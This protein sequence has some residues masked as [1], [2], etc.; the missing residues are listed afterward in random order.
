MLG[1]VWIDTNF[2]ELQKNK[3][4]YRDLQERKWKTRKLMISKYSPIIYMIH[5]LWS[6]VW[7]YTGRLSWT[8]HQFINLLGRRFWSCQTTGKTSR[9]DSN[10]DQHHNHKTLP[11]WIWSEV[12]EKYHNHELKN[13]EWPPSSTIIILWSIS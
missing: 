9:T 7:I 1:R 13:A 11:Q 3:N 12:R 8:L 5:N 2:Q 10:P 4:K 6:T